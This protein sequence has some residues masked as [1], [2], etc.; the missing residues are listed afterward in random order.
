MVATLNKL[1]V[2]YSITVPLYSNVRAAIEAIAAKA[3][4]S[5]KYRRGGE[6]QVAETTI[7]VTHRTKRKQQ[8]KLRLVVPG[9]PESVLLESS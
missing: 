3:W 4:T 8:I 5:I 7:W 9:F 6:A 1:G 2:D